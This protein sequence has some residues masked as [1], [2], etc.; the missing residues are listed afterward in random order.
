MWFHYVMMVVHDALLEIIYVMTTA[1]YVM[2]TA[3]N[4]KM[5]CL[6]IVLMPHD[7]PKA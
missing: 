7:V 2:M 5:I 6:Q 4:G 3:Y 1:H